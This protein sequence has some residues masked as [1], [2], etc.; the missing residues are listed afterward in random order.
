MNETMAK[1]M[2]IINGLNEVEGFDPAAFL[3]KLQSEAGEEQL[4]LDVKY[5]KLWFRLKYPL[6]KIAKRIIKLENDYAIIE[7]RIY[8]D[9]NDPEDNYISCAMAQRWRTEDDAYGKKYVESAETA[10]VGRAL[11]DAGF[12]IQFSEPGEEH[13]PNPV[14]APVTVSKT[15]END[16]SPEDDEP[17]PE[18]TKIRRFRVD[19]TI[20]MNFQND[21]SFDAGGKVIVFGEH[22]STVNENMPLRSLLYIG[23]AYER[24]VPP[25]SRYKKKIVFLPTPEFYTFYNGKEKW[26][27]EKELRL[28]DA[29]IV[30]D[31]E[32]SLELKVKVINIRPEEHHE[33]L[34]K[35]QVLKEYSQFMEIVQNYQISGEEEPYKKAIKECIEKGILADYLM[36]KG[37]EVVNMLLDEYDYETD[38]EVQREEAREEGRKQGE[39][40]GRKQGT[41]QK[42]CALIQKK[43]EKGKTISEIADD[44]ED[45]EENIV[46]LIEEFHLGRKES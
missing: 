27:K 25:R 7:S 10:A 44:L 40:E 43:L 15:N 46:H 9:R 16:L 1:N 8:L 5:R 39:E 36:R 14:D 11:A 45:T 21:I 34:E 12:G 22:Q 38:I 29:Y 19:N 6:G 17:L 26:E 31:G 4:Y 30:K 24:L 28:S 33:I 23:R 42:T 35:C 13:D 18:G 41:L 3:R 2:E 37:S 20:Y 32:P